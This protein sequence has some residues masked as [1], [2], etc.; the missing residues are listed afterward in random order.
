MDYKK[1][2]KTRESRAAVLNLLRFIPDKLMIKLQYRIKH[3]RKLNLKNPQ[4]FSEKLQWYKLY[5]RNP[6][7][8]QCADKYDVR[9]YI[10]A[11]GLEDILVKFYKKYDSPDEIDLSELPEKFVIKTTNGGG[12]R[13]VVLC[14]DKSKFDLK[15][16][17]KQLAFGDVKSRT[18]GREWAYYGLR[19]KLVVEEL[20][21]NPENEAAGVSDYK[22]FCYG[23]KPRFIQLNMDRFIGHKIAY[24][25]T[26]WNRLNMIATYDNME[27]DVPPPENLAEMMEVASQLSEDFPHVRVDLY[28]VSGKIYFGELTFYHGSGYEIFYPDEMDFEFG[29]YFELIKYN[30][31]GK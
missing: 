25:D 20:L 6:V 26:N 19:A 9:E 1:I 13:D 29:K 27:G 18:G 4:R 15:E 22:F 8:Q 23:G 30:G 24:Y 10:K 28:S 21:I 31:E 17:K 14:H 3:N 16:Y 5:H 12:G 2:F 11:K 7:M